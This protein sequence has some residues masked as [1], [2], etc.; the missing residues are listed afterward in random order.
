MEIDID[1][2]NPMKKIGLFF[3]FALLGL[4]SSQVDADLI[5]ITNIKEFPTGYK[6]PIR[7]GYLTI[8]P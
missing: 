1:I 6:K 2:I 5:N 7:A 3:I 4:V 8:T